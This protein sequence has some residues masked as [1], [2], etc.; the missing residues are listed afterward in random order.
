MPVKAPKNLPAADAL[1]QE[2]IFVMEIDRAEAQDIRPLRVAILNLMPE[3]HI[4]ERQLL[5][6]ISNTPLQVEVVLLRTATYQ[7]KN[8]PPEH[9]QA[10]Y[11]TFEEISEKRIKFDAL[12]VTGAPVEK[13]DFAK[14]QYWD[15]LSKVFAW[16]ESNVYSSL[17][18]CWA[19]QAAMF[20]HYG[21][22]KQEVPAKI[23]GVFEHCV[24]DKLNPLVRGFDE[25]FWAP[26]SRYTEVETDKVYANKS[27]TV[28]AES[29]EAGLYLA[30][31]VDGRRV[32]Q[33]GHG[34]YDADTLHNEYIRDVNKGLDIAPPKNYYVGGEA[35]NLPPIR[36]RAHES[37]LISNWLNYCVYQATP[38]DIESIK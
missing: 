21:I 12:I 16:A 35:G 27:L 8:A 11:H 15:E 6:L 9:L 28:L 25:S 3:K 14:V 13:L 23:S 5:R 37:L 4:T 1:E 34:E 26:H 22:G 20:Y 36:W 7:S 31:S 32:F 10:F 38:Y 33:F 29:S 19:A 17:Y 30:A 24:K 2:N 18:I